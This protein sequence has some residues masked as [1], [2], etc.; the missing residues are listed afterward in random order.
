MKLSPSSSNLFSLFGKELPGPVALEGVGV[1][2]VE[3]AAGLESRLPVHA[4]QV[5]RLR[6][7]DYSNI[8]IGIFL[9]L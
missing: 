4:D 8:I 9:L 3:G 1:E 6:L 7:A 5:G 2:Y